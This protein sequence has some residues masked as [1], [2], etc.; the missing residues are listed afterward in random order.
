MSFLNSSEQV[1][2]VLVAKAIASVGTLVKNQFPSASVDFSPWRD[3]PS[4]KL[5]QEEDSLDFF[6]YKLLF[7]KY[8]SHGYYLGRRFFYS[9]ISGF[10]TIFSFFSIV[11]LGVCDSK[12]LFKALS[13]FFCVSSILVPITIWNSANNLS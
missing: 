6:F 13:S 9:E 3:D 2:N 1:T 11:T 4:T 7:I 10:S 8:A 12:F 5:W